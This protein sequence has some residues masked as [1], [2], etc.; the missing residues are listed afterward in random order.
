MPSDALAWGIG[1]FLD[2]ALPNK[3]WPYTTTLFGYICRPKPYGKEK[4]LRHE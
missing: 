4:T 2:G 3:A 1:S